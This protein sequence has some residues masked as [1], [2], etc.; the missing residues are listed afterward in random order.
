MDVNRAYRETLKLPW[1]KQLIICMGIAV[2]LLVWWLWN[3]T[4][5]R[6][7]L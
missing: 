5:R 4:T 6:K 2:L 3:V 1:Y 7:H